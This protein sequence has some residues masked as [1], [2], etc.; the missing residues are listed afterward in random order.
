MDRSHRQ[1]LSLGTRLSFIVFSLV[2]LVFTIFIGALGYSI[3]RSMQASA[4]Q[5][6]SHTVEN[7]NDMFDVFDKAVRTDAQ[8][9]G[10][11]FQRQ[12]TQAFTLNASEKL[13]IGD[14]SVATLT[15]GNTVVNA[16]E[17]FV[18]QFTQQTGAI[19]TV[20]VKDGSDFVRITT[21]L[22]KENGERA[23][24]TALDH[25]HPAYALLQTEKGYI[26]AAKLFG[27]DYMTSY[28]PIKD[29]QSQMVGVLFVGIDISS[30]LRFLKEKI[31][32]MEI[33]KTGTYF[34]FNLKKGDS[35]GDITIHQES[36]GKNLFKDKPP[37]ELD[38]VKEMIERGHGTLYYSASSDKGGEQKRLAVFR[39]IDVLNW[40]VVGTSPVSEITEDTLATLFKYGLFALGLIIV[41][42]FALLYLVKKNVIIPLNQAIALAKKLATGDLTDRTHHERT[43]EIG[44]LLD[45]INNI[46]TGLTTVIQEVR[47]SSASIQRA[48]GEI[49]SGNAD[50]SARTE[51]QASSLEE[52]ASSMEELTATVEKNAENSK[53]AAKFAEKAYS[54]A[55]EGGAVVKDVVDTMAGIKESSNRIVDITAVIDGIAFQTNILALNAAVEAAR[56]GEQGRGFAVVASEVRNLAQRAAASAKE[57]KLLIGESV[58]KVN[59]G[60]VLVNMAGKTMDDIV[61]NLEQTSSTVNSI[62]QAGAEQSAGIG[63]VNLAVT[64]MDNMTQQNAA[65]VE[66]AAAAAESLR[67]QTDKLNSL[68]NQFRI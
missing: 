6:V 33:G 11:T 13:K 50:L 27:K 34:A 4:L 30:S 35:L 7:I 44:E 39:K 14:R 68:V 2:F 37:G 53:N 19:A 67:E 20:F 66:Q 1:G 40:M 26:G 52:T 58:E 47:T 3:Y 55:I 12:L 63:Q 56:A 18:D 46:G 45:S 21:S 62:S 60:A 36:E 9:T 29:Q 64:E 51:S 42:A 31:L 43:D 38:Y 23:V 49:A 65:L 15:Y 16:N 57:I 24:G 10:T 48:A 61:V 28:M 32:A 8:R 5:D 41:T 17:A 54:V 22:K 25:T 59:K